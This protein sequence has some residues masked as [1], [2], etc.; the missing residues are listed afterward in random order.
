MVDLEAKAEMEA[1][2][3]MVPMGHLEFLIHI[4]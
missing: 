1:M 4:M 2:V 3:E